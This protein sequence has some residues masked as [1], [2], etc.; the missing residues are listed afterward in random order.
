MA[1][2]QPLSGQNLPQYRRILKRGVFVLERSRGFTAWY[3]LQRRGIPLTYDQI[4]RR[5]LSKTRTRRRWNGSREKR[6]G[7][8]L[9]TV[10][11]ND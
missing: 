5:A 9:F 4:F 8:N 10:L 6:S 11:D 1:G 7:R 2:R 3:P